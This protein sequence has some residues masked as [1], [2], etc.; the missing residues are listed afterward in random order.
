[1]GYR[2]YGVTA[3]PGLGT[4]LRHVVHLGALAHQRLG[5]VVFGMLAVQPGGVGVADPLLRR[6]VQLFE[7][8]LVVGG[9]QPVRMVLRAGTHTEHV[10]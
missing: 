2:I 10:E 4:H 5:M 8:I 9:S 1:M 6:V 7:K 3:F